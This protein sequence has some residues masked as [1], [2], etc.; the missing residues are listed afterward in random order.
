VACP[1]RGAMDSV[2]RLRMPIDTLVGRAS[3]P[4]LSV[5]TTPEMVLT[6]STASMPSVTGVCVMAAYTAAAP[7]SRHALAA[8]I[9][10]SP[11]GDSKVNS[12]EAQPRSE[13]G[14]Q[15]SAWVQSTRGLCRAQC[16]QLPTRLSHGSSD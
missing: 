5:T 2:V 7:A 15:P 10:V 13:A 8:R 11:V 1:S 16:P 14:S 4:V 12:S 6:A 9:T 3:I